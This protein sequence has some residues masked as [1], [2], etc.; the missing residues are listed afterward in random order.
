MKPSLETLKA[1]CP[2]VPEDFLRD[3]LSRLDERYFRSVEKPDMAA[4][5]RGLARL[6]EQKPVEILLTSKRD[7]TVSC[8]VLAFDCAYLF[9]QITGVLAGLGFDIASGDVFTYRRAPEKASQHH[10][11]RRSLRLSPSQGDTT[12]RLIID[13]FSGR[14]TSSLR[15]DAWAATLRENMEAVIG[16]LH[17]GRDEAVSRAKHRVIEMVVS[18]LAQLDFRPE[19][20]LAPV[21]ISVDNTGPFTRLKITSADSPAFLYVLSNALSLQGISIE[22]VRIRTIGKQVRDDI[23]LVDAAGEKIEDPD[24]L[25]RV[26]LAVLLT[27]QFT[28]FLKNAPAPYYALSRFEHLVGEVLRLP[29]K[30]RWLDLLS[31]PHALDDLAQVLG[32]SDYLWED[33]IRSQYETFLPML[34]PVVTG[35]RFSEPAETLPQRL[36]RE[37]EGADTLDELRQRLNAFKDR[38]IFLIDLDHIL[39]PE[40]DF[41]VLS[42]RLVRLAEHVVNTAARL[43]YRD[44]VRRFGKPATAAGLE[45]RYAILGLGKLGGAA[46]GYASDIE[47]LVVYSDNGTTDGDAVISNAEFF[48]RLVKGIA[49]FIHAKREGIFHID[50]R[51]RPYGNDGP[52]ACSLETFCRYYGKGGPAHSYERLAL[53]RL[54]AIGGDPALGRRIERIRNELIYASK[55]IELNELRRLREKQFEEKA[56]A[57]RCNAKFSPGGLVDLEYAIQILQVLYG[58]DRPALRTPKTHEALCELSRAGVLTDQEADRLGAAYDFFRQLINAMRMVRGSAKD[59]FLPDEASDEFA[60]LARRMGYGRQDPLLPAQRLRVDLETHM[61]AIRVFVDRHFGRDSLP[62]PGTGTV[63][64][65]VLADDP[66]RPLREAILTRAGFDDPARAYVNLCHLAGTGDRRQTFARLA[67]F[68]FD[69]LKRTP[70]PDMALNNWERFL[71]ALPSVDAHY[72]S[73]L[74]QPMR[75]EILLKIFS[76]SQFLADTLIRHPGFLDWIM[77]PEH[78]QRPS[79]RLDLEKEL[80][81]ASEACAS[82]TQW[83]NKIRRF[84]RREILRIGTRDM[85][86]RVDTKTIMQELSMLAEAMTQVVL[87]RVLSRGA[88]AR[89]EDLQEDFC[90]MALGKLG[91]AELNYSSDIDLMGLQ[92]PQKGASGADTEQ[93]GPLLDRCAAVMESLRADLSV[94]TQEGYAYRVDLR[95]RPYGRQG[96]LVPSL[97]AL[98]SYYQKTASLWELQAALKMRP[99]AGNLRVGY[100]FLEQIRPLFHQARPRSQIVGSIEKMRQAAIRHTLPDQ[101]HGPDVKAGIGGLRDVEFLVQGLQLIHGP[102]HPDVFTANT[103]AGLERLKEAGILPETVADRLS[104]DYVFLRRVEHCLQIMEDRQVHTLPKAT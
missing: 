89:S 58:K 70:D 45:A 69:I 93:R 72:T 65:L 99:V 90:V 96:C 7:G 83:Q 50:L 91:G 33:F 97:P 77:I 95:L 61:A 20:F 63:A 100:A 24:V 59:L 94:H 48:D 49:G 42:R 2:D 4:H 28:Y 14:I 103:L 82:G 15:F 8:T 74:S 29:Q 39:D 88:P 11:K 34:R 36:S 17:T 53:V 12:R 71:R 31:N 56:L 35:R 26:R 87:E 85:C 64:D 6:S 66:D 47:I 13:Q 51:L 44:L 67:L 78:L 19:A 80:R 68:A 25:N 32:A 46:L 23:D 10:L 101:I 27:K 37:L 16:L 3:Y 1:A 98:I 38:E 55:S 79:T 57:G 54:R 62:G 22:H 73:L 81:A 60:H 75:L 52:L 84:R 5:V 9:A 18:Q 76:G 41:R 102:N 86:L 43:V 21:D 104:D 40:T 92:R 30:G